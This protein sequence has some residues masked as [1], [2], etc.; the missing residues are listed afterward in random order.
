MALNAYHPLPATAQATHAAKIGREEAALDFSRPAQALHDQVRAFAG[1]P[2]TSATFAVQAPDAEASG[3]GSSSGNGS[4]GSSGEQMELKIVRTRVAP[5]SAWK[6]G[7]SGRQVAV[8]REGM[9]I[10]CAEGS[11]LEVLE[12]QAPSKK[13]MTARDLANGLNGRVLA[14]QELQQPA[15]VAAA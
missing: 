2:G 15:P 9:F 12:V 5:Q 1:W 13:V 14:W 8:G 10:R 3:A 4:S 6:G 11:V 7:S